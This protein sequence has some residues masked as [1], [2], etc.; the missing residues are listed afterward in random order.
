MS[1][2]SAASGFFEVAL[3][4]PGSF[5]RFLP[6]GVIRRIRRAAVCAYQKFYDGSKGGMVPG[7]HQARG[8]AVKPTLA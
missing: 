5:E 4:G 3:I 8:W 1:G 2:Y 7:F 6:S